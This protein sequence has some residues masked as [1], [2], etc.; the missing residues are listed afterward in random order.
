VENLDL[1]HRA[2]VRLLTLAWADNPFCGSAFGGGGGLTSRG[3]D[4]VA[5]CEDRRILVDVSHASDQAFADICR[6]TTRP[7]VASHS[8][9]RS[10]CPNP[11]NLTDDMIRYIGERGGLVGISVVPSFLSAAY[12]EQDRPIAEEFWRAVDSGEESFEEAGRRSAA[13]EALIP[14]PSLELIVDH[15]L[16]VIDVGGEEA[17]G[18]GGDLD[19]VDTLPAGMEG[20]GDYPRIASLLVD[21]GLTAAQVEKVCF[22]NLARLFQDTVG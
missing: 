11:R 15:I 21:A 4:L 19:G 3:V 9:C 20:V 22:G 17:V 14:R 13:A 18:L 2:G 8:N 16:H 7:F 1:F 12:Y 5:A 6:V 10:L